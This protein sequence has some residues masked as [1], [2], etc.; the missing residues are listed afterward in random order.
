M[1][2]CHQ[3]TSHYLKQYWHHIDG[4]AQNCSNFSAYALELLQFCTK[5]SIYH[6]YLIMTFRKS[7]QWCHNE[8]NGLSNY[9]H[10]DCL[11][12]RLF[13]CRSEKTS[14]LRITGLCEGNPPVT[15]RFP[16]QRV[17]TKKNF[18]IGWGE[19]EELV[20]LGNWYSEPHS[21][22]LLTP[23]FHSLYKFLSSFD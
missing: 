4:L 3:G 8:C 15:G 12:N 11:L 7:L 5:P 13:R 1:A 10:L 20:E 16:S 22:A 9:R 21:W 17:S 14:K 19:M 6:Y 2:W 18:S 23:K